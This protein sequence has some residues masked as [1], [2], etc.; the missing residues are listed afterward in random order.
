M[1][2]GGDWVFGVIQIHIFGKDDPQGETSQHV[3]KNLDPLFVRNGQ[4]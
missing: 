4:P 3:P 1:Q 2:L